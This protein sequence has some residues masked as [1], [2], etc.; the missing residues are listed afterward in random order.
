M[1]ANIEQA[2]INIDCCY[3]YCFWKKKLVKIIT[4]QKSVEKVFYNTVYH[5]YLYNVKCQHIFFRWIYLVIIT[6]CTLY[7]GVIILCQCVLQWVFHEDWWVV[8]LCKFC[9]SEKLF[10]PS[11]PNGGLAVGRLVV[12]S[13]KADVHLIVIS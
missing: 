8:K 2:F 7:H 4:S 13:E 6:S 9:A 10:L 5:E 11:F 12:A 3:Y 1:P